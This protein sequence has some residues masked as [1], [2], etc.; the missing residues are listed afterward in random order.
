MLILHKAMVLSL[1]PIC[2]LLIKECG[3]EWAVFIPVTD[4]HLLRKV[5][6][7]F[8]ADSLSAAPSTP[9]LHP[10]TLFLWPLWRTAATKPCKTIPGEWT[11]MHS[12]GRRAAFK[13]SKENQNT[14]KKTAGMRPSKELVRNLPWAQG[15]HKSLC[16]RILRLLRGWRG[17]RLC[18]HTDL[19]GKLGLQNRVPPSSVSLL[20]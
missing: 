7:W 12:P 8:R 10:T 3:W 14:N 4:S 20:G 5:P 13:E 19:N 9:A 1:L 15:R 16:S 17:Q 6:K 2:P 18:N 11:H